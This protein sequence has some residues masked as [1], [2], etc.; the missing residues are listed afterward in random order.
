MDPS[1]IAQWITAGGIVIGAIGVLFVMHSTLERL[2]RASH[3]NL[4]AHQNINESLSSINVKLA[5]LV[6]KTEAGEQ[7]LARVETTMDALRKDH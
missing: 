4:I 3:E 1:H 2:E 7:R 6:T 5:Q